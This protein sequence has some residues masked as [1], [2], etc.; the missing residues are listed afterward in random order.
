MISMARRRAL[1]FSV[2]LAAFISTTAFAE[3]ATEAA[4]P[5][6][7]RKINIGVA[8]SPPNVVHTTPYVA[9]ELGFFAK[10]CIEANIVQFDGGAAGTA[11][12]AVAQGTAIGNL[13]AAPIAHGIH[14]REI[15][16]FAPRPP[17][18]YVVDASVKN[19]ADLKGKRLSAAGGVGG[20]NWL[21]AREVLKKGELKPEDA[22]FI[23]QGT[24]GRLPGLLTGQLDGVV[25]HPEDVFL[26]QQKNPSLH[27]L[28]SLRDLLPEATFN[29]YGASNALIAKDRALLVDTIAAMIEANRAIYQEKDKVVPIMIK[30]TAKPKDAVAFAY[31]FLTKNCI[32]AVNDGFDRKNIAWSIDNDVANGDIKPEQKPTV[33]QVAD[34]AFADEAVAKAGGPRTIG[35]CKE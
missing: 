34:F 23:S 10:H 33:E 32:W 11:I 4:C 3:A 31:D 17:Q 29:A 2:S 21:I 9:Q 26:A 7:P 24:A 27:V 19:F 8:V 13:P 12:T 5:N 35:S 1:A 22:T 6:G 14:A 20:Y 30:A 16:G 18:S 28:V 15:W 25:L